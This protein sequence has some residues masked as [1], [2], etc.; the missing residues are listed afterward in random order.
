MVCI[1]KCDLPHDSEA[2]DQTLARYR[3]RGLPV[4]LAAALRGDGIEGLRAMLQGTTAAF[5]GHS[6]V[7]KSTLLNCLDTEAERPTANVRASDGRGRHTTTA[8]SLRQLA[9][10]TRLLDTPGV[11]MFGLVAEA[12]DAAVA[13]PEI[14]EL[15]ASCRFRDCHHQHEP[16]CAVH[17]G[18]ID[19]SPE[20]SRYE[21]YLRLIGEGQ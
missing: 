14:V 16:G 9:D 18:T 1:N 20:V 3:D 21:A 12:S 8:S 6:G 15:S 2:R 10:A 13:F 4:L 5:V 7:G 17:A 19:G 11:R